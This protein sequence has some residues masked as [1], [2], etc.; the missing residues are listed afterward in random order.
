MKL[1]SLLNPQ[2]WLGQIVVIIAFVMIGAS[3]GFMLKE[4][5]SPCPPQQV[6]NQ[7]KIKA[8]K[9]S[10]ITNDVSISTDCNEWLRGLKNS[11]VKKI[12]KGK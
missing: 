7:G 5:I 9:G 6:I 3:L 8:K 2:K 4:N 12:R 11:E 10:T 1:L